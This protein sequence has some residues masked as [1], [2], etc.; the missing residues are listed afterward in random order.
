MVPVYKINKFAAAHVINPSYTKVTATSSRGSVTV[1]RNAVFTKKVCKKV[2]L[3]AKV[4]RLIRNSI[5]FSWR[6][7][8]LPT[9]IAFKSTNDLRYYAITEKDEKARLRFKVSA[10]RDQKRRDWAGILPKKQAPGLV[11]GNTYSRR[12]REKHG[13]WCHQ[14]VRQG[15]LSLILR[16]QCALL[17]WLRPPAPQLRIRCADRLGQAG[18]GRI[19]G[20][21]G[22][23]AAAGVN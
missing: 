14:Y 13:R 3:F 21:Q 4:N 12:V 11:T 6:I 19:W 7:I 10:E 2:S 18:S 23:S 16:Q 20:L 5:V 22:D 17:V 15:G 1:E 9:V 8:C